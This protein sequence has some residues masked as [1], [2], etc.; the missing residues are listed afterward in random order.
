MIIRYINK[1]KHDTCLNIYRLVFCLKNIVTVPAY[2]LLQRSEFCSTSEERNGSDGKS[3][4]NLAVNKQVKV[5]V[6]LF[7]ERLCRN[8]PKKQYENKSNKIL[9]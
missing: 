6:T 2:R 3:G 9:T 4:N 8:K 5:I 1:N 7:Y